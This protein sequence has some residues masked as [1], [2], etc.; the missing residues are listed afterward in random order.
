MC[1]RRCKIGNLALRARGQKCKR[2]KKSG[3]HRRE[4]R[5]PASL[6]RGQN[7]KK[8]ERKKDKKKRKEGLPRGRGAGNPTYGHEGKIKDRKKS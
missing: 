4:A 3:P 8:N 5:S 6:E 1:P 7:K 2:K